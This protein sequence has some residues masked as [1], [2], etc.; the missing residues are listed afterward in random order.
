M[1]IAE[2]HTNEDLRR[3]EFPVVARQSYFGHAG[4]SPLPRRVAEAIS[5]CALDGARGDQEEAVS[6]SILLETREVLARL[7][8]ASPR[9]I[10]LVGPTSLGLSLVAAGLPWRKGD[11]LLIYHDDYP[12]NVY[13]WMALASQGVEVRLMNVRELGRIRTQD[14]V[15]QIDE[16]TRLV[17]LASCHFVS[18]WRLEL[19]PLGKALR[20]RGVLFC[21]DAIQTLGALPTTVEAVDFL[22]ADAHKW[23]L[24]PCA[25]GVLYVSQRAQEQLRPAMLGWHNVNCPDFVAQDRLVYRPDARR[26]EAGTANL[27]GAVGMK[28]GAEL[29]LE[30]GIEEIGAE[31]W[32]KRAWLVKALQARGYSVWH[33]EALPANAG[34]LLSFYRAGVDMAALHGRLLEAGVVTSLRKDRQGKAYIRLSPHFYNTDA[35]LHR[36]VEML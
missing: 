35:E 15:G 5:R 3:H 11:N 25:A 9:E 24:G 13:P 12:A 2:L 14:V 34:P 31:A 17:A 19:G 21:V 20:N 36:A 7:L 28:A 27:L 30:I 1:T 33:A 22:A 8:K 32:R 4:V 23:L 6:R 18:G 10:A 16:Q 29:L 26:Y